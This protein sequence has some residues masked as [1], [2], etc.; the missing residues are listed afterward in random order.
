[1]FPE[2]VL[3][4]SIPRMR[5]FFMFTMLLGFL[6][7]RGQ[8]LFQ[9]GALNYVPAGMMNHYNPLGN[10]GLLNNKWSLNKYAGIS[11]GFGFF[12]GGNSTY[13]AAPMGLQVNRRL[14]NN[15]FAVA[16]VSVAPTYQNFSGSFLSPGIYHNAPG[17]HS[18]NAQGLG[19]SSRIEAGL[20][21]INNDRTFSI[22]GV[23]MIE[24]RDFPIYPSY[25]RNNPKIQPV[26]IQH[27]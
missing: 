1:M 23:M 18:F 12:N 27:Q 21:Y 22:M 24:R 5:I 8:T 17:P 2:P 19:L 26:N 13:F 9:P 20:M 6:C 15:L 4:Y 10:P 7:S 11:T 16:G 14:N 25:N 3:L